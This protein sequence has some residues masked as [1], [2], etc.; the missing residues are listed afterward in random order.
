MAWLA[1]TTR[2]SLSAI[3]TPSPVLSTARTRRLASS[4]NWAPLE[5]DGGLT[6]DSISDLEVVLGKRSLRPGDGQ[7]A[8]CRSNCWPLRSGAM[9]RFGTSLLPSGGGIVTGCPSLRAHSRSGLFFRA[10]FRSQ[11]L[12]VP[13][14][15]GSSDCYATVA[16]QLLVPTAKLS[17]KSL[18]VH[19]DRFQQ[20]SARSHPNC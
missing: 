8:G 12:L 13:F 6:C 1:K 15:I 17:K 4:T 16:S 10:K 3:R 11:Q 2:W 14:E 20:L 18:L 19:C 9:S 5:C 7:I